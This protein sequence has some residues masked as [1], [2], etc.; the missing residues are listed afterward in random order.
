MIPN[1][2]KKLY[3]KYKNKKIM[4]NKVPFINF[5]WILSYV[6]LFFC[7]AIFIIINIYKIVV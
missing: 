3:N 2:I 4:L 6:K 1:S 7:T 5:L